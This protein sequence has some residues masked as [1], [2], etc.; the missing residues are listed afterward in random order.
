MLGCGDI[1]ASTTP[2][3]M[4]SRHRAMQVWMHPQC[5]A[6]FHSQAEPDPAL[7]RFKDEKFDDRSMEADWRTIQAEER[8]SLR[9]GRT[10]DEK[11]EAE[12]LARQK[13]KAA[14]KRARISPG[15]FVD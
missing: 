6:C 3:S 13:A 14:K 8:R 11:A 15:F 7:H 10:E 5:R 2:F 1:V 12:E 4:K 9:M